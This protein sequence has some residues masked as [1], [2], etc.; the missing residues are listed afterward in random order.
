MRNKSPDHLMQITSKMPCLTTLIYSEMTYQSAL[1][2]ISQIP[3]HH[4]NRFLSVNQGNM[5]NN[6]MVLKVGL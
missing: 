1:V 5:P 6:Q 2:R 4:W 3:E